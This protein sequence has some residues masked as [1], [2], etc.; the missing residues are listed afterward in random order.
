MS[1]KTEFEKRRRFGGHSAAI[2][3]VRL[4]VKGGQTSRREGR[5]FIGVEVPEA[6]ASV[7]P[8]NLIG[9]VSI[10]LQRVFEHDKRIEIGIVGIGTT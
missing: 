2:M 1:R 8:V 3:G 10:L 5:V 9:A 4:N 7:V 6:R